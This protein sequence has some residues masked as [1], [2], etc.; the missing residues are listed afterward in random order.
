MH[1]NTSN[2]SYCIY[3]YIMEIKPKRTD[4]LALLMKHKHQ[5]RTIILVDFS[6][7]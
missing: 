1:G 2:S 3:F 7:V 6:E 5:N 4:N